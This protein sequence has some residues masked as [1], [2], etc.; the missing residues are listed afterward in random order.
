[1]GVPAGARG[2][3]LTLGVK[4]AASTVWEILREAWVDP[5]P[6]RAATSWTPFRGNLL[7]HPPPCSLQ[8]GRFPCSW[9]RL[10]LARRQRDQSRLGNGE[11][12]YSEW[13]KPC[14]HRPP[15]VTSDI[16]CATQKRNL[17]TSLHGSRHSVIPS[18]LPRQYSAVTSVWPSARP[19]ILA[20]RL[21]SSVPHS[22]D[23]RCLDSRWEGWDPYAI[24]RPYVAETDAMQSAWSKREISC[25]ASVKT[26][27]YLSARRKW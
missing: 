15:F 12:I 11:L 27:H 25:K 6:D 17:G 16:V 10:G 21:L 24:A 22:C 23:G 8:P 2:T 19:N 13:L 9:S 7:S 4:V 14:A 26:K 3:A 20:P 1:V 5:A 18:K